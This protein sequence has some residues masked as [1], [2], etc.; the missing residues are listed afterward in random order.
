MEQSQTSSLLGYRHFLPPPYSGFPCLG[1]TGCH[2]LF[3]QN[4]VEGV[5]VITQ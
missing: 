3:S 1:L 5:L 4:V 2:Y